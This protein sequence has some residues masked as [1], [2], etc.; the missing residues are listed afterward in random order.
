MSNIKQSFHETKYSNLAVRRDYSKIETNFDEPDLLEVQKNSYNQFLESEIRALV[1][2]Y[3][4]VRH[5]KSKYEVKYNGVKFLEANDEEKAHREGKTYE[6]ALYADLSLINNETGEVRRARKSKTGVAD[7]IFFAN[8]PVMTKKGTFIVNGIE[9][10]VI[11]QIVRSPGVYALTKSQIK[12]NSKKKINYGYICEVLPARGTQMHFIIDEKNNTVRLMMRN[13][14]GDAAPSFPATQIL[15]AFGMTQDEILDVFNHDD[16]IVNTLF[17]EKIYNHQNILDDEYILSIRKTADDVAKGKTADRGSPIDTKLKKIV[18]EYVEGK[19]KADA[20]R[21]DYDTLFTEIAVEHEQLINQASEATGKQKEE[22]NEKIRRLAAPV[23]KVLDHLTKQEQKNRLLTDAIITEKA[24]KDLISDL[25][26]S[27]K[28]AEANSSSRNQICYQDVLTRHFMDNRQYDLT[29]AGRYKMQR[30]LRISER[31]YQ[32]VFAE[33]ILTVDGKVLF[34][35]GTLIMKDELDR[36]KQALTNGEVKLHDMN[37]K[38][39]G[40]MQKNQVKQLEA[41]LVYTD[42]ET[43]QFPT[44]IVGVH[45]D[46]K[47][48][49]LTIADFIS[50]ISYTIGLVHGIGQYDDIDHLGNKRLRLIHEQLKTKLQAGMARVEKHIKEKLASISIP[51]ANEEQQAKIALKTTI[52]SVVNTKAF[53]LVVKNFFN[54]YQLTQFIDQ[55]N[56]L[57]ELTNKR[58]ISAMGDGGISRE[59]PNLD[60]RDVHY[61]HYGRICPIET[62]EGMNIGLIMS[63]ASFTRVDLK[64]GFLL[65]P[66]KR[67]KKGIIQPEIEWLTSLREDE[68]IICESTSKRDEKNP[69]RIVG[70]DGKVIGRYRSSQEMFPVDKV[71]YIEISPRQ[72]VSVAA[73]AIPFLENDDTTRALMGANMQRQAVPLLAP[74]APIVGTGNEYKISHDSGMTVVSNAA[75]E[76]NYIDGNKIVVVDKDNKKHTHHLIKFR[77]SNQGTCINQT[78][79]VE[80]GQNV[81]VGETLTDGPAMQNGELALGR[82]PLVAFT[83]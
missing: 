23:E 38:N 53:Q 56:P 77:K 72:V 4:P 67:V 26:I 20:L 22:L 24:A 18:F 61:S 44:P 27:T 7:G 32:R 65:S 71:D 45:G 37:L 50:V 21:A 49:A 41:V 1:E 79:I 19:K 60:I 59:D 76:V 68:Y 3:F 52:K 51:T 43:L 75:G 15:K 82:N 78:P 80:I 62:P 31:L 25:S 34:K 9:K 73:S 35:K 36:M 69:N 28:V 63:L 30:K 64:T 81:K 55:Q 12:L 39:V 70:V 17:S 8:I 14:L 16:Y 83:T 74:Y 6:R 40:E 33:D 54:S 5:T 48:N 2:M 58:R 47:T 11:S 66:Y 10:I 46:V 13:A 42:N 57:S 29:H